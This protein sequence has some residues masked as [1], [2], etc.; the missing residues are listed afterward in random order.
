VFDKSSLPSG[1]GRPIVYVSGRRRRIVGAALIALG[2]VLALAVLITRT[3][4]WLAFVALLIA[5]A[6][7]AYAG[8]GR[9]GFYEVEEDGR[10]GRYLGRSR[11]SS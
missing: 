7:V 11:P 5:W 4:F 6:G 2:A 1:P 9:T 10:L 8:G 3:S